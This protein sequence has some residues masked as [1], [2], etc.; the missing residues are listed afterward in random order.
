MWRIHFLENNNA[1]Y[2]PD[3]WRVDHKLERNFGKDS[4]FNK[5]KKNNWTKILYDKDLYFN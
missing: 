4:V 1:K 2:L 5:D 3:G